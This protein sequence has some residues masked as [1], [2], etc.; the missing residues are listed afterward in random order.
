MTIK[1]DPILKV[2]GLLGLRTSDV[3][4]TT[5]TGILKGDGTSITTAT[6][7]TDYQIPVNFVSTMYLLNN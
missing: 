3:D 6:A 1:F 7:G 2:V 5:K 4:L